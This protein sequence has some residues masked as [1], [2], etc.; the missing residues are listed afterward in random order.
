MTDACQQCALLA[1]I[2]DERWEAH[3][4]EHVGAETVLRRELLELNN[5]RKAFDVDR[6]V[7]VRRDYYDIQHNTLS[8]TVWIGVGIAMSFSVMVGVIV[9][10]LKK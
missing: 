4:R 10:L 2:Q 1:R 6:G 3:R 7:F 8:R 9:E 5:L